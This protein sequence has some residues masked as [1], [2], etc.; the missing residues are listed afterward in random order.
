MKYPAHKAKENEQ[1]SRCGGGT[2]QSHNQPSWAAFGHLIF[3]GGADNFALFTSQNRSALRA[4]L[5]RFVIGDGH[6][7][8]AVID[9]VYT[10]I[11]SIRRKR[12]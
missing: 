3:Q 4:C 9:N 10:V 2:G 8:V 7:G 12:F 11:V 1:T 5:F 6:D